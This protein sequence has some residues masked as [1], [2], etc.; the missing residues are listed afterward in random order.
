MYRIHWISAIQD[1][2][3]KCNYDALDRLVANGEVDR[4]SILLFHTHL[5]GD[6]KLQFGNTVIHIAVSERN[7]K[8]VKY[9]LDRGLDI[10]S[11]D[12][13]SILSFLL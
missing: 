5:I 4:V 6:D 8:V 7:E 10:E 9:F 12:E 13:V 11:R 2:I 1:A 3:R